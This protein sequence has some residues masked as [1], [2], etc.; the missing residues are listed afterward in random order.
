MKCTILYRGNSL[1]VV[2][3]T[4]TLQCSQKKIVSY[5]TASVFVCAAMLIFPPYYRK[6]WSATHSAVRRLQQHSQLPSG[7]LHHLLLPQLLQDVRH[8]DRWLRPQE[9]SV[10]RDPLSP[11]PSQHEHRAQLH[12]RGD[13][14]GY[15]CCCCN[16]YC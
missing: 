8:G 12:V 7:R 16:T 5:S 13:R 3:C 4:Q 9:G 1:L 2:H 11:S 10:K 14:D 6:W 15:L